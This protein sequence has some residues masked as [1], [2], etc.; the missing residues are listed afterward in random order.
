MDRWRCG[1]HRHLAVTPCGCGGGGAWLDEPKK[2]RSRLHL[3]FRSDDRD[4]EVA[5]RIAPGAQRV[6]I[7]QA[8][9]PWVVLAQPAGNEFCVL[10][11]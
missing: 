1:A 5:R 6:D 7:A 11:H 3:D 4:A 2:A 9:A 8:E 10:S